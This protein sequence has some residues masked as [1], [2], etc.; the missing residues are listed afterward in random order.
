[1]SKKRR[2]QIP[3]DALERVRRFVQA[4][5]VEDYRQQKVRRA[6]L[7]YEARLRERQGTQRADR[8][9]EV[10]VTGYRAKAEYD[11]ELD[12]RIRLVLHRHGVLPA[13]MLAYLNFARHVDR[14]WRTF[15]EETLRNRAQM[16]VARWTAMGLSPAVLRD[17]CR[18]VF[19]IDSEP[20]SD[21][22]A[23]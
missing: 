8:N 12:T 10:Q 13:N 17:L 11:S 19:A 22:M 9:D 1:M 15:S 14:L 6:V 5:D 20:D 3:H 7:R 18:D 16:A 21:L 4:R 23:D 2:Q